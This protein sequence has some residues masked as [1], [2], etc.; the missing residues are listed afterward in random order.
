MRLGCAAH[1]NPVFDVEERRRV[2]PGYMNC[3]E[4]LVRGS[5][6]SADRIQMRVVS[7]V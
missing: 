2:R 1:I 4:D 7:A 6:G 3:H 5:S